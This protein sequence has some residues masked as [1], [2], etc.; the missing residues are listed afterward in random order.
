M[1]YGGNPLIL[2]Y[3]D[4]IPLANA[5]RSH[6]LSSIP[7]FAFV[8]SLRFSL[9]RVFFLLLACIPSIRSVTSYV[10]Y[11]GMQRCKWKNRVLVRK[12][13]FGFRFYFV[14]WR[15]CVCIRPDTV[16]ISRKQFI[17]LEN[18]QI[19][20]MC[21]ANECNVNPSQNCINSILFTLMSV[22]C[23]LICHNFL[24]LCFRTNKSLQWLHTH[25]IIY[26]LLVTVMRVTLFSGTLMDFVT[27][28]HSLLLCFFYFFKLLRT[29][30]FTL[31][32]KQRKINEKLQTIF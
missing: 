12:V 1:A 28:E 17:P 22:L 26:Y 9:F 13:S 32:E 20:Y 25:R 10:I 19:K 15:R 4:T 3:V 21:A 18:W 27:I 24:Q 6:S 11:V 7:A 30:I 23:P 2:I 14:S 16:M 8:A 31:D 29:S 5:F